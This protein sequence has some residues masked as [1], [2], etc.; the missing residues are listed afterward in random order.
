MTQMNKPKQD[1]KF[2]L[3]FSLSIRG[4]YVLAK[5]IPNFQKSQGVK[6]IKEITRVER[7]RGGEWSAYGA[8]HCCR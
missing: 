7:G 2:P 1:S 4:K 8:V 3:F 5:S 6:G